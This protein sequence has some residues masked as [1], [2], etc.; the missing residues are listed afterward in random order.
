MANIN[1]LATLAAITFLSVT[2]VLL[3][4][5]DPA[6]ALLG[7]IAIAAVLMGFAATA[8]DWLMD[9]CV[10]ALSRRNEDFHWV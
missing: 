1:G 2:A 6:F 8:T 3:L 5:A 9:Q 4:K 7:A 10:I